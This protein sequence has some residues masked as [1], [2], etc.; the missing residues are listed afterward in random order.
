VLVDELI[1]AAFQYEAEIVKAY[2][3][4]L[5]LLA[6]DELDGYPDS[7]FPNLIEELVLHIDLTFCHSHSP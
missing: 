5:K 7:L 4:S 1:D 6:R 2:D 3:I